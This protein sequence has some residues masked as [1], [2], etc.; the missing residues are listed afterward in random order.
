VSLTLTL[1]LTLTQTQCRSQLDARRL[2]QCVARTPSDAKYII[3][4]VSTVVAAAVIES[5]HNAL[6]T[7]TVVEAELRISVPLLQGKL[8][9]VSPPPPTPHPHTLTRLSPL[10]QGNAFVVRLNLLI[11]IHGCWDPRVL[12]S[13]GVGIC[14][15]C[16]A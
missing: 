3:T 8:R 1:T 7:E 10:L 14:T 2:R 4:A 12:G 15:R 16:L 13:T 11:L 6:E 5:Y 9:V